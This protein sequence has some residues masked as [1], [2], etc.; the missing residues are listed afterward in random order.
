MKKLSGPEGN[1]SWNMKLDHHIHYSIGNFLVLQKKRDFASQ[2]S[3]RPSPDLSNTSGQF[4]W[5]LFPYHLHSTSVT[6]Q[7]SYFLLESCLETERWERKNAKQT[8]FRYPD[9]FLH[10]AELLSINMQFFSSEGSVLYRCY[11][12]LLPHQKNQMHLKCPITFK[13]ILLPLN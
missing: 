5:F 9:R 13:Y 1:D 3:T 7:S 4:E 11:S 10:V 8:K 2:V 12:L 6:L